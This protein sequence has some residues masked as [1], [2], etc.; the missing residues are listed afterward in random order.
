MHTGLNAVEHGDTVTYTLVW[1]NAWPAPAL[2][3][4]IKDY[5]DPTQLTI[6]DVRLKSSTI[7]ASVNIADIVINT[8][9]VWI[10]DISL[11]W[12][13]FANDEYT[14]EVDAVVK[15]CS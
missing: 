12:L 8:S 14:F 13:M 15:W 4:S 1:K 9:T 2:S 11:P 5:Y 10:I 6:T 3:V 7:A